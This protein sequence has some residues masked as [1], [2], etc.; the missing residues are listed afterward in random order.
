MDMNSAVAVVTGGSGGLGGRI[1]HA[2]ADEGR[3]RRGVLQHRARK[4]PIRSYP[5]S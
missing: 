1:C 2:L 3:E 5:S 4:G